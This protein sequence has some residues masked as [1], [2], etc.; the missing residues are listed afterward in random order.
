MS[1]EKCRYDGNDLIAEIT[2]DLQDFE[3]G[4]KIESVTTFT[5]DRRDTERGDSINERTTT[6]QQFR[7]RYRPSF[8]HRR[9]D[10]SSSLSDL[11]IRSPTEPLDELVCSPSPEGEMGVTIDKPGQRN[12]PTAIDRRLRAPLLR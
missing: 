2:V 12:P 11:E 9:Y 1:P 6:S 7:R 10:P 5:F 4:R 3:L 8:R